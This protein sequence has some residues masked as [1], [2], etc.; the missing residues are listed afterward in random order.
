MGKIR[1][2]KILKLYACLLRQNTGFLVLEYMSKGNLFEAL[3]RKMKDGEVELDWCKRYKIG[4]GVAKA[5]GYLHRDCSPPIIHRDIKSTNI[6]LDEE[7]EPQIADFGVAR[8][9]DDCPEGSIYTC[10]AGT[11]GYIAPGKVFFFINA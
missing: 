6:L 10:F 8:V 4:L 9:S 11:H 1:H 2:T 7:Y 5:L 3:H